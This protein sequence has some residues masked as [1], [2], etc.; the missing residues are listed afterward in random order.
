MRRK[1]NLKVIFKRPGFF[2]RMRS[3]VPHWLMV[4]GAGAIVIN[5]AL[6]EVGLGI[7]SVFQDIQSAHPQEHMTKEKLT[8]VDDKFTESG[9]EPYTQ[10]V[11]Q[12]GELVER[13]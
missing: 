2:G 9:A 12:L 3:I 1:D 6:G 13:N 10:C 8:C 11:N 7:V 4:L 5:L